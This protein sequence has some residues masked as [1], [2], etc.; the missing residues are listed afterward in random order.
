MAD[1]TLFVRALTHPSW[2]A[3]NG[4]DDYER[5]EFLGDSVLGLVV[6]EHL[7]QAF[8]DRPEGDLTRMRTS[9]V[10][11]GA[12]AEA[13]RDLGLAGLVRLGKGAARAEEGDR[14]SVLEAVFEA[15][16]GAVYLDSGLDAAR[17]FVLGALSERLEESALVDAVTDA[18]TRLQELTQGEGRGLPS[19][20]VVSEAGPPHHR[21]FEVEAVLGDRVLGRGSGASK[22]AASQAAAAE[23]LET[24]G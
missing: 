3:E 24:L 15:L 2:S 23:A 10:R 16:V 12:L 8:P 6:A 13:A 11:G 4:G 14:S 20:R 1:E 19:Y 18:K 22:Q 21:T 5:L 7:H 17:R 9:V